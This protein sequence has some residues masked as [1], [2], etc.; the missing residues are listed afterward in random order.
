MQSPAVSISNLSFAYKNRLALHDV[1]LTV[2]EGEIFGLLGPNGSGKTTL[3]KIL[4][5]SAIPSAGRATVFRFDVSQQS[6]AVRKR[7]GV[8]FQSF[9]L[10]KKLKVR[11]NLVR[12][13]QLHGLGGGKLQTRI[14]SLLNTMRLWE[15]KDDLVE[16]LSGG[17]QRR[18]EIAKGLLHEPQLLL[19]DEP[20]TGLDPGARIDLWRLL[21]RLRK[22][23][24]TT[25]LLTT[26]ILEEADR[27]DRLAVVHGGRL[28][29]TGT[30]QELKRGIGGDIISIVP[31]DADR[32]SQSIR[33]RFKLAAQVV[34]GVIHLERKNGHTFIPRLVQAFP[35]QIRSIT[36]GKPTLQ[37]V[38]IKYTG[39]TFSE[40]DTR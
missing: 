18:V 19:M 27:C 34:D 32:L 21:Y 15:R 11:E 9:A 25:I 23:L 26:H 40:A 3:F 17:L 22:E 2:N 14:E 6:D 8:V 13:G 28:I 39:H 31:V 4:S 7:I 29:V 30:P 10:D 16:T 24:K 12:H 38:F 37:D 36:V 33:K 35:N 1:T 5:T 20:S